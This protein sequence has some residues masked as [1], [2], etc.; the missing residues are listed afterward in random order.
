MCFLYNKTIFDLEF[1]TFCL[2]H[3]G[4]LSGLAEELNP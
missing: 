3:D 4:G 2:C 1:E